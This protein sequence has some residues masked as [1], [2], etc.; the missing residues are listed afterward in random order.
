[1]PEQTL[2]GR[3]YYLWYSLFHKKTRR[4]K[5]QWRVKYDLNQHGE[6]ET[7]YSPEYGSRREARKFKQI[8]PVIARNVKVQ[9]RFVEVDWHEY[10]DSFGWNAGCG[11]R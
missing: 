6:W 4:F 10:N 7:Y 8:I 5:W 3:Q 9:R 11:K 2:K 1:M